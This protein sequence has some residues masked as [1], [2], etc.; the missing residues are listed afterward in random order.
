MT[1]NKDAESFEKPKIKS[2]I[3]VA[4]LYRIAFMDIV[5]IQR[6]WRNCRRGLYRTRTFNK[7]R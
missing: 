6:W 3:F 5:T 7:A 4:R 2:I 1:E